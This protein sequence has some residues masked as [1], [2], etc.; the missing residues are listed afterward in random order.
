MKKQI[1]KTLE[2]LLQ[3]ATENKQELENQISFLKKEIQ[4]EAQTKYKQNLEVF[5]ENMRDTFEQLMGGDYV[6]EDCVRF[7]NMDFTITWNEKTVKIYNGAE[8][9]QGIEDVIQTE[10]DN[11]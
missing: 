6:D 10:I 4:Q 1:L 3:D 8:V 9:F 11:I 7:Y 2:A 5:L